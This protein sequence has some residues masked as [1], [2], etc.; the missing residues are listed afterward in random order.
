MSAHSFVV[1]RD[2]NIKKNP[3]AIESHNQTNIPKPV[4]STDKCIPC[5]ALSQ[6]K[7]DSNFQ[8]IYEKYCS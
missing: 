4:I 6:F 8:Q 5:S 3:A 7:T 1:V 2:M